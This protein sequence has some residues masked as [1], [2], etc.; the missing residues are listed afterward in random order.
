MSYDRS[1]ADLW[2]S[3]FL[4]LPW[5]GGSPEIFWFSCIFYI[6]GS[7][8]DQSATTPT[9]PSGASNFR[10][11]SYN[12][13]S[14]QSSYATLDLTNQRSLKKSRDFLSRIDWLIS[15]QSSYATLKFFIGSGPGQGW[16]EVSCF[17]GHPQGP[18]SN[19]GTSVRNCA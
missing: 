15:E 4:R 16:A 9:Q 14:A 3:S 6:N 18:D 11:R 2:F 5:S 8:L 10:T 19:T 7:A 12:K 1:M 17:E 13:F